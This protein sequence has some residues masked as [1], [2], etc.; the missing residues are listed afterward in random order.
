MAGGASGLRVGLFFLGGVGAI[1]LAAD[2]VPQSQADEGTLEKIRCVAAAVA[3]HQHLHDRRTAGDPP[4]VFLVEFEPRYN[5]LQSVIRSLRNRDDRHIPM[6]RPLMI[7]AEA[8]RD[9]AVLADAQ[10]YVAVAWAQVRTCHDQI[11]AAL[12]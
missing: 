7:E 5:R 6:I 11:F 9:A 10:A 12:A 8:A 1:M 4:P 2:L 3:L